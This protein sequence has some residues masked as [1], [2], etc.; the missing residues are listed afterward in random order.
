MRIGRQCWKSPRGRWPHSRPRKRRPSEQNQVSG[1]LQSLQHRIDGAA[2][3]Q[4]VVRAMKALAASSIGQYEKAVASLNDY[5]RTVE[6]GLAVCLRRGESL[7]VAG[8]PKQK[9]AV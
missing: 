7:S 4:G 6:L 1:D 2:D 5:Y 9:G 8:R 3:L